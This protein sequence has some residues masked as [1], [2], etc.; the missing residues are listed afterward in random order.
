MRA[1]APAHVILT[2]EGAIVPKARPRVTRTGHAFMPSAYREWKVAAIASLTAQWG[3]RPQVSG[4]VIVVIALKGKHRRS[5]DADNTAGAILDAMVQAG[6]LSGDNLKAVP[7]LTV[8][9]SH[10]PTFPTATI[11]IAPAT[12]YAKA[13][14]FR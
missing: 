5:G 8:S 6:I 13:A 2:L 7:T 4:P 14:N 1:P 3:D 11:D 12:A 9:L 10:G